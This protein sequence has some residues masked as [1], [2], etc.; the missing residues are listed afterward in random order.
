MLF[1]VFDLMLAGAALVRLR[2]GI[3]PRGH[4]VV[5]WLLGVEFVALVA[6]L[7]RVAVVAS[8][9]AVLLMLLLWLVASAWAAKPPRQ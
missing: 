7:P 8:L 5:L 6:G 4:A 1:F 9:A 3:Q 2:R